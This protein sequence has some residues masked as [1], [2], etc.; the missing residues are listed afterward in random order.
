MTYATWVINHTPFDN[1]YDSADTTSLSTF[2]DLLVNTNIGDGRDNF[3]FKIDNTFSTYD[4]FFK[5]N[6]RIVI[7]RVINTDTATTDDVLMTGVITTADGTKDV[8]NE[9]I[10]VSGYN[11]SETLMNALVFIDART[12]TIPEMLQQ[13]LDHIKLY[14]ETFSVTWHPDNPDLKQDNV[15][16]F[17]LSEKFYNKSM[18][19]ILEKVSRPEITKDGVYYWY[20]DTS[21]RLVWRPATQ[22]VVSTFDSDTDNYTSLVDKKDVSDV[23]NFVIV[24][25]GQ[26]PSGSTIQTKY[27]DP[28][29]TAK[30]GMKYYI[31]SDSKNIAENLRNED[32]NLASVDNPEDLKNYIITTGLTPSW[33]STTYTSWNTYN[34][35]FKAHV[36]R[37]LKEEAKRY[38]DLHKNGKLK[39]TITRNLSDGLWTLGDI[40]AC[41]IPKLGS[42]IKNLRVNDIQYT[43]NE[44]IFTLIEDEGTI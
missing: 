12:K 28:V 15:T 35:A 34:D 41:T 32:Q 3:S 4:S 36:K 43:Q 13:A 24:K 11:Y 18:K 29:S 38:V 25:G 8:S 44:N 42:T 30:N 27:Y 5:P 10:T 37:L 40:I 6:D 7:S 16:S 20:I 39:V 9:F 26:T 1:G 14:S 17:P 2:R 19:Y 22:D 33:D 23:K 31:F 21:N